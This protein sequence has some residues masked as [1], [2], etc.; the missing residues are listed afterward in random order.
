MF[1]VNL[2]LGEF[3]ALLGGS[4]VL[5][6]ALYLL[7]RSRR[8]QV[9]PTLRFWTQA[10]RPPESRRRR[11][12][13]Q[14]RSLLLQWLAGVLLLAA[15]AE[16]SCGPARLAS[17]DH[18]LLLDTSAWMAAYTPQGSL[19]EQARA[20]AW[21]CVR[22]LPARDR[23]ML[24]RVDALATP[25][26]AFE[27]ERAVIARAIQ[28]STP[29]ATGLRLRQALEFAAR[30]LQLSGGA[31][32]EL[33]YVGAGR[34]Q[35]EDLP[36]LADVPRN[37]RV[38]L[39]GGALEN[40]GLRRIGLARSPAE[41]SRWNVLV[42]VRNY[43]QRPHRRIL[44]LSFGGAQ[45]G[46]KEFWLAPGEEQEAGFSFQSRAAG[47]LHARLLGRDALGTDDQAVL[48]LPALRPLRIVV[49]SARPDSLRPLISSNPWVQAEYRSP[50][51]FQPGAQADVTIFDQFC[52]S[53]SLA[54]HKICIDPP[55]NASPPRVQARVKHASL[56]RW[57]S[58]HPL[59][60]GIRSRDV[61]LESASVL[62]P[63]PGDAVVAEVEA[64]PVIIA[65]DGERKLVVLGFHPQH[66]S[67]RYEVAAPLLFANILRWLAPDSFRRW[68]ARAQSAGS[69]VADLS[70]LTGGQ[71]QVITEDGSPVPF[72]LGRDQLRLFSA[73]A[74]LIR[75]LSG[76]SELVYSLS[77]PQVAEQQWEPPASVPRGAPPAARATPYVIALWPWLALAAGLCLA[78]EWSLYGRY[79]DPSQTKRRDSLTWLARW[80]HAGGRWLRLRL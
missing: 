67:M 13:Q 40:C 27:T 3:L 48:E 5:L 20:L 76:A 70:G 78:G 52:P 35:E 36:G 62:E 2:T 79:R 26:T 37:L 29:T 60:A 18:V 33:I 72:T 63:A 30:A 56:V 50:A 4:S 9:V 10:Q 31:P 69:L 7:D 66:S 47:W 71:V 51:A 75:V 19:M 22:A 45:V 80:R 73:Q 8:R 14:W 32:G 21:A 15:L 54:S 41:P 59:A 65:R 61:E 24:L 16:L 6:I 53:V 55:A 23:V 25:A 49:Y 58:D 46:E 57:R 64:G 34:A 74:H 77:L 44:R 42:S 1:L 17:R 43:G 12:I 11:R 68:E 38:V 39:V 28:A